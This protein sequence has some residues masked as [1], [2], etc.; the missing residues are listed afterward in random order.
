M[1]LREELIVALAM[2]IAG[3][4]TCVPCAI[5]QAKPTVQQLF[6]QLQ[7]PTTTDQAA[8]QLLKLGNADPIAR[9]FLAA[10]LPA[11]IDADP[12]KYRFMEL[13]DPRESLRPEWCNAARLAGELKLVEATPALVRHVT[14]RTTPPMTNSMV[15]GLTVSP[16]GTALIQIGDGAIPALLQALHRS[17]SKPNM[18]DV[19]ALIQMN[20]LKARAA[21]RDYAAGIQNA[22]VKEFIRDALQTEEEE[23]EQI[24]LSGFPPPRPN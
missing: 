20:S 15:V 9:R 21:L 18:D 8:A 19:Y 7:S 4:N 10:H 5:A 16:A 12:R 24:R 23:D 13:V 14:A 3:L 22:T 2:L 11:L 17:G 1:H 6:R